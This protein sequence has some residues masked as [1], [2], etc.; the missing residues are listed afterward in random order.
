MFGGTPD[1]ARE[2]LGGERFLVAPDPSYAG[3]QPQLDIWAGAPWGDTDNLLGPFNV[4]LISY[5]R[6]PRRFIIGGFLTVK[7]GDGGR[8]RGGTRRGAEAE[9][10][11][12]DP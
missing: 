7:S 2:F 11:G 12:R 8:R 5:N 9:G 10:R 3:F 1:K 6:V 4:R